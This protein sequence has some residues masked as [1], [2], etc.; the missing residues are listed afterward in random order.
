MTSRAHSAQLLH[1]AALLL[2]LVCFWISG[3]V[4]THHTDDL[5]AYAAGYS[6]VRHATPPAAQIACTACEWEQS[7]SHPPAPAVLV[8]YAPLLQMRY[9]AILSL[10]L[11]LRCFDYTALRGPP[12]NIS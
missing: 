3:P 12:S 6:A 9:A 2:A 4:A 1:R 5:L 11:H 10:A 7:F 8:A